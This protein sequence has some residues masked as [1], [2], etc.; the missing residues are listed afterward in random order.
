MILKYRIYLGRRSL[1]ASF[2]DGDVS[3]KGDT[4]LI[5]D[6]GD[7]F[8]KS[9]IGMFDAS[10]EDAARDGVAVFKRGHEEHFRICC[11]E[12]WKW[13]IRARTVNLTAAA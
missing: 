9:K 11:V 8:R 5:E 10:T 2:E 12:V 4:G 6:M 3:F 13:D 1:V 7:W